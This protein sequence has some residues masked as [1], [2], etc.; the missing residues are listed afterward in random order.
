MIISYSNDFV[1]VRIPKCASTTCVVGLY[2]MG[3][4]V[5]SEG[6][7]CSG[8]EGSDSREVEHSGKGSSRHPVN[9]PWGNSRTQNPLLDHKLVN[10]GRHINDI[11]VHRQHIWHTPYHKIVEVGLA[12][13]GM[14][15]VST[16]RHPVSRFMSIV[17]YLY[18]FSKIEEGLSE[19][20][21]GAWDRF[22]DDEVVFSKWDALFKVPQNYFVPEGATLFNVENTYE[23]L[24]RFA[25]EKGVE[26]IKPKHFKNNKENQKILLTKERQQEIM[27]WFEDDLLLW[28]KSYREFN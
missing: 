5:E 28:E 12:E 20:P 10:D 27:S 9:Y 19:D 8:I 1:F 15:C 4:V 16:I 2:D 3:M 14:P 18:S 26:Y 17:S 6:D 13:E 23:W 22:K 24:E 11:P 21:N 7:I 25:K